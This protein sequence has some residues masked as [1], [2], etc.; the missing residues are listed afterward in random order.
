MTLLT[1]NVKNVFSAL[2]AAVAVIIDPLIKRRETYTLSLVVQKYG[3]AS[4]SDVASIA[5]VAE[6]RNGKVY[7]V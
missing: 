6:N 7:P 4:V 5:K 2:R 1:Y 3:G